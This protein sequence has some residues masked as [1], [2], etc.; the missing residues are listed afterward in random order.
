M[1][2][3]EVMMVGVFAATDVFLFYVLFEATLI[4]SYFL[5]GSY[6]RSGQK[7]SYAAVKFL[8]YNL[9]G[10]LLMLAAVIGLYVSPT[11]VSDPF[12]FPA[13]SVQRFERHAALLDR[14]R[15]LAVPRL[16][17]RLRGQGAAVALPHLAARR[18]VRGHPRE[19]RCCSSACST[20]SAPSGCC[21]SASSCSRT[22]RTTSRR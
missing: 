8:L 5:I 22:P 17:H 1:L 3:L 16:L 6:G 18:R 19:P 2:V 4:P 14:R 10:G 9:L 7:R 11:A 20:R 12:D 15:A 21:A 13:R